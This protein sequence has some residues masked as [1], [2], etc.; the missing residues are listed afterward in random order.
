MQPANFLC[1]VSFF[2]EKE[3]KSPCGS[4][5]KLLQMHLKI[6]PHR[7]ILTLP[8]LR[9]HINMI[10]PDRILSPDINKL[11]IILRHE[12]Q[13]IHRLLPSLLPRQRKLIIHPD[14]RPIQ[15]I[16]STSIIHIRRMNPPFTMP[17]E[18][19]GSSNIVT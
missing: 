16:L 6:N 14:G 13:S 9:N 7:R 2:R 12:V 5:T 4:S 8:K 15:L 1:F 17:R 10:F 3:M 11:R 18:M 19:L